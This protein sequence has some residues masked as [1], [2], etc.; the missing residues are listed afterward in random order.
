[1]LFNHR[2][3]PVALT[4]RSLIRNCCRTRRND[5]RSPRMVFDYSFVDCLTVV[6]AMVASEEW[7]KFKVV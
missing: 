7:L 4:R 1:M 5:N 6:R 3:M 2:N